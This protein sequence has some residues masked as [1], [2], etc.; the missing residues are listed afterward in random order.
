MSSLKPKTAV[1]DDQKPREIIKTRIIHHQPITV[2]LSK[3]EY[4]DYFNEYQPDIPNEYEKIVK[5]RRD[6]TKTEERKRHRSPSPSLKKSSGLSG[7]GRRRA[8]SDEEE[9]HFRP[10]MSS[11]RVGTAIAPPKSLQESSPVNHHSAN[12]F[13]SAVAVVI[14]FI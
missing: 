14:Y 8:S 13:G 7:F 11:N 6:K 1:V 12:N 3:S 4:D 9:D 5:E 10:N 2:D